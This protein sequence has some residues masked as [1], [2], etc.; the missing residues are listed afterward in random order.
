[1]S[2]STEFRKLFSF[3]LSSL[4]A[5][6]LC[7]VLGLGLASA[8]PFAP[9]PP[10]EIAPTISETCT[11][12]LDGDRVDDE[13]NAVA[14]DASTMYSLAVTQAERADALTILSGMT[15]VE[16]IFKEQITQTQID[17]FLL[18]GGEISYIYRAVSY[19]WQGRIPLE[20][21]DSFPSL[22]GDTL[23]L[24]KGPKPL[25]FDMDVATRTGRVR[26]VWARGFA[27]S[28]LGFDGNSNITIGIID[29]GVDETHRDLAGNGRAVYWRDFSDDNKF[30]PVDYYG[31]G[32]HVAGIAFGTGAAG[33]RGSSVPYYYTD[34][35]DLT[36]VPSGNFLRRPINLPS[37]QVEWNSTARWLGGGQASLYHFQK[38][39]GDDSWG[40][41]P[42]STGINGFSPL[43]LDDRFS[44]V[45]DNLYSAALV[46]TGTV[47]EYVITNQVTDP[48]GAGDEF[49]K[50]CGVAPGC[51]W[52]AAKVFRRNGTVQE[53][54]FL[55][56]DWW[57]Y[58]AIDDFIENRS[59]YRIKVINMSL[60]NPYVGC[61][62]LIVDQVNTAADNGIVFTLSAG[63]DGR[64]AQHADRSIRHFKYA[65]KAI[66]VGASNDRNALTDYSSLGL[67][68][69]VDDS[70]D[71]KPDVIAPGGSMFSYT[72]ILSVDSGSADDGVFADQRPHDYTGMQGTSMASPFVAGCAALVI[73][74]M[75][76]KGTVWDFTSDEH[77]L[78][79]KMLLCATATETGRP[80][81]DGLFLY[82]LTPQ[83]AAP[84]PDNF[85][86]GK[87]PYEGY[88][89]VNAD[90]AVEAVALTHTWGTTEYEILG[91]NAT[92]RR[93]WARTVRL[94]G[95]RK[96]RVD[97][98]NPAGCDFDLYLYSAT[99]GPAGTPVML[100][101]STSERKGTDGH[102]Q[103]DC[104][105][106]LSTYA[107]LVVKRV[108]GSG[109]FEL[110]SNPV[111]DVPF[112]SVTPSQNFSS[113]GDEGGP[114]SPTSTTYTL[115][116]TGGESLSW[117]ASKSRTWVSLNRT[118]GTL[119]PGATTTVTVSI[120][121]N[122]DNLAVGDY[123]D[124][125][126]FTN[127]TNG[128]GNT[129]RSVSLQVQP[130]LWLSRNI[131]YNSGSSS[132]SAGVW[133][134]R[135]DAGDDPGIWGVSDRFHYV[136]RPLSGDG[137][138]VARIADMDPPYDY[139][140]SYCEAGVMIRETLGADSTHAMTLVVE[141]SQSGAGFRWRRYERGWTA[142]DIHSAM[143]GPWVKVVREGN[144]FTG[145]LSSDSLWWEQQGPTVRIFMNENVYVGLAVTASA[146]SEEGRWWGDWICTF[147]SV[148]VVEL[149]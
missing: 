22:M 64:Q 141:G 89:I 88:G 52:A 134:V 58:R 93:A 107:L 123:S 50:F 79:V 124:T 66:T 84:G 43:Q 74:A 87:D 20:L 49:N 68:A 128:D 33:G 14:E 11:N 95:G 92:D 56:I 100:A 81:E 32:S 144:W 47:R 105:S 35:G 116:N 53:P 42:G 121:S 103:I 145:Y 24:L 106:D 21:V 40:L 17:K 133:T 127:Q 67:A 18:L 146:T 16:L 39:P 101:S 131:G 139:P 37:G 55:C 113:S 126:S 45:P 59:R 73:D 147:D 78:Y 26:P 6:S 15:D 91:S 30:D 4:L 90:A 109:R 129:T 112:L 7:L 3:F 140:S 76:Q 29:S 80:R 10:P 94:S 108:S 38:T 75:E 1:M 9:P 110:S 77:P 102:E 12:D 71:R 130:G 125:V 119:S 86:P 19:G 99:A 98:R 142:S 41:L 72:A 61:D 104:T 69:P 70:E 54:P 65:A 85:P 23:V 13:L 57:V 46:K 115:G 149:P 31:H 27:G 137:Y 138:I 82:E 8:Q 60:K 132:Q 28:T 97:L 51:K 111:G 118:G 5:V 117:S 135:T 120:N 63:N 83:K 96:Y 34:T 114:F 143:S 48:P 36:D 122:A 136:Y 2:W 62:T 44:A 148:E 25:E